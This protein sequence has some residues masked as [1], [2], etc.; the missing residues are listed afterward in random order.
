M[1]TVSM[2]NLWNYIKGLSLSASN[3]RW[4]ASHLI[5]SAENM[6]KEGKE[7]KLIF[8]KIPKDYKP[9]PEIL[10]IT[11]GPLPKDVDLEKEL[12]QKWEDWGK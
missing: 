5:E 1:N 3:Q 7:K 2:D 12:E 8:P 10:A 4:L 11:L 6:E 9:S